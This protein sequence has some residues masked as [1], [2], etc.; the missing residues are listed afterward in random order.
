MRSNLFS[1]HPLLAALVSP[2]VRVEERGGTTVRI[3]LR[4]RHSDAPPCTLRRGLFH[5]AAT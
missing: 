4:P 1:E 3:P 2:P 5:E